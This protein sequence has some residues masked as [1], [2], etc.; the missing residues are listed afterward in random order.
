MSLPDPTGASPVMA[1]WFAMK[2]AHPD[3]L[4]FLRMGDFYELFFADAEAAAQALDI[5]LTARGEHAGAPIAMCGVPVHAADAYLARLIRRGF[6]V[7][8]AEQMEDPKLRTGKAPIRREVV[9]LVTPGTVTEE[10]L[11]DAARPNLLLALTGRSGALGAAWLDVSTGLFETAPVPDLPALLGRLDPAEILAPTALALG[12]WEPR[13]GPEPA[14]PADGAARLAAAFGAASLEAF[15]SFTGPE[16]AA[17][18]AAVDYVRLT[19][20]GAL[21]RL[22]RPTPRGTHGVLAMDPATRAGLDLLRDRDGGTRHSLFGVTDRTQTAPGARMLAAWIASPLTAPAAI[23]ARQDAWSWLGANAPATAGIRAAL[24]S[25]PDMARALGRLSA[26]RGGPRD[27]AVIRAGL[28]AARAV[29]AALSGP[30]PA[31]LDATSIALRRDPA[32]EQRLEAALA[33][34]APLRLD[35]APAIRPGFDPELDAERGLRDDS[36]QLLAR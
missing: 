10:S 12:E 28:A 33:E 22:S 9:R 16:I 20:A 23:G 7:A 34:P 24:R 15:G 2:A 4:L 5:A 1:Q 25:L 21:P 30:L 6:R 35:D 19:S 11:L 17:A 29:S 31:L 36:R 13:R 3:A 14:V 26:Q 32:L 8:V 27:L 18:A